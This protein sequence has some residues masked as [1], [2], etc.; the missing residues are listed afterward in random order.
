MH[1]HIYVYIYIYIYMY[2]YIY[3]YIYIFPHAP[4][5]SRPR[6]DILRSITPT[7]SWAVH[8]DRP[9]TIFLD[10]PHYHG[11]G[12]TITPTI[13]WAVHVDRPYG[14]LK[15]FRGSVVGVRVVILV[16]SHVPLVD[17]LTRKRQAKPL[18]YFRVSR[19]L[20]N[21]HFIFSS[22]GSQDIENLLFVL[23]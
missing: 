12:V 15:I 2:I 17:A 5:R 11:P 13:S 20:S 3:I 6:Y 9:P 22:F 7:I 10:H 8:V 19:I 18:R 21:D 16:L 14:A 23:Y 4:P 1:V